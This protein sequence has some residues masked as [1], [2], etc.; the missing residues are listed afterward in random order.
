MKVLTRLLLV[1]LIEYLSPMRRFVGEYVYNL[2]NNEIEGSVHILLAL[3]SQWLFVDY[4]FDSHGFVHLNYSLVWMV[5]MF[6]KSNVK[7]NKC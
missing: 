4:E 3:I 1:H 6:S 7:G 5:F 2:T